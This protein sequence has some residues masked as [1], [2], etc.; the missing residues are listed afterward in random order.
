MT[1]PI[2]TAPGLTHTETPTTGGSRLVLALV[3]MSADGSLARTG[4]RV[5]IQEGE[6]VTIGR[7][8]PARA[9]L[10]AHF[11]QHRPG[12][13]MPPPSP[14]GGL[15]GATIS[16]EQLL[17][18]GTKAGLYVKV[19]GKRPTLLNGQPF[20]EGLVSGDDTLMLVGEAVLHCIWTPAELPMPPE[21]VPLHRFGDADA[22]GIRGESAASWALRAQIEFVAG[23]RQD[24]LVLGESGTGKTAVSRAIHFRS[25]RRSGPI[26]KRSSRHFTKNVIES[27]LFGTAPGFVGAGKQSFD[28]IFPEAEGG[29][30]ILDEIGFTP[31]WLQETLLS[32]L[33]D[34]VYTVLGAA[35]MSKVDVRIVGTTNEDPTAVFRA[36]FDA[37]LALRVHVPPTRERRDDIGLTL[38]HFLEEEDATMEKDPPSKRRISPSFV[39]FLVRHPLP[40]NARQIRN[41][42]L[43]SLAANTPGHVKLPKA[44]LED[45]PPSR[46]PVSVAPASMPPV[47]KPREAKPEGASRGGR[48]KEAPLFSEAQVRESL[49]ATGWDVSAVTVRLGLSRGQMQRLMKHWGVTRPEG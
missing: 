12:M 1:C 29:T 6:T 22:M 8:D 17:V 43:A 24:V 44:L 38:R 5:L 40:T 7:H 49:E 13:P 14:A 42:M 27:Q 45:I 25:S 20:T 18:T 37:R 19:I 2:A 47:S 41:M 34:G 30:I 46:Q 35:R 26:A 28:G 3:L 10:L 39:H 21:G 36:D 31:H 16:H 23:R 48:P 15:P 32:I 33:D 9:T 4:E 11:A